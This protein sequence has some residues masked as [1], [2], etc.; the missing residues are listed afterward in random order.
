MA[1]NGTLI[2]MGF[3]AELMLELREKKTPTWIDFFLIHSLFLA[4]SNAFLIDSDQY[5]VINMMV[6]CGLGVF[7]I[8]L[9]KPGFAG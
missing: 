9:C 4:W 1:L 8:G 6:I 7:F 2:F 3:G 5:C